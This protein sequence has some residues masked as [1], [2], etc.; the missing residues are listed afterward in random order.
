MTERFYTIFDKKTGTV[1]ENITLSND[2]HVFKRCKRYRFEI[3]K[4]IRI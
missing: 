1:E 2:L 3:R 4:F